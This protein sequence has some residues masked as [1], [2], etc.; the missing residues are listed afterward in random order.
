MCIWIGNPY[1]IGYDD[2][3][4]IRV[5]PIDVYI[6]FNCFCVPYTVF[7]TK[8]EILEIRRTFRAHDYHLIRVGG[9]RPSLR[10]KNLY[11]FRRHDRYE[12]V[13]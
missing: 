10:S 6:M 11:V 9:H 8:S 2:L 12:F 7:E 3:S 13:V 1:R 5:L 4:N